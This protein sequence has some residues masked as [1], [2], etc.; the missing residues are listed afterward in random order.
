MCMC[1]YIV[2]TPTSISQF[3]LLTPN[4]NGDNR[5]IKSYSDELTPLFPRSRVW[6]TSVIC[7]SSV[8]MTTIYSS[9]RW[10]LFYTE[11]SFLLFV[12]TCGFGRGNWVFWQASKKEEKK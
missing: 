1:V 5:H 11:L 4:E 8:T 6:P 2:L 3:I 7:Q 12:S 10:Q 9:N